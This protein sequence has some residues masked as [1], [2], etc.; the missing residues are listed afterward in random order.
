M[1]T[2]A[3]SGC[4]RPIHA[5]HRALIE[6]LRSQL[7]QLIADTIHDD[8]V[9]LQALNGVTN[10]VPQLQLSITLHGF[11]RPGRYS[12]R[13]VRVRSEAARE[14]CVTLMH[15][16]LPLVVPSVQTHS[17]FF[18]ELVLVVDL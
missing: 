5:V 10:L 13:H 17:T 16:R 12:V 18:V 6:H 14:S 3:P 2:E 8:L 9:I 11:G 4:L 7:V 1:F 15:C